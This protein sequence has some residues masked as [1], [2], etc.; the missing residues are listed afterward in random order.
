MAYYREFVDTPAGEVLKAIQLRGKASVKELAADLD[1]SRSAIRQHLLRLQARG[2]VRAKKVREGVG[3]PYHV[4]SVTAEAHNLFGNDYGELTHLLLKEVSLTHGGEALQR[5]LR[6]VSDR[7]AVKYRDQVWGRELIDRLE[8]WAEL[9]DK[10][11]VTVEIEKTE[12]GYVLQEY[13]CPYQNVATENR[14]VC[15]MERQ[16][17]ARLLASGVRL[18]QC[19]L[20]GHHGCQFTISQEGSIDVAA[21]VEPVEAVEP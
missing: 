10:K 8:A 20:D 2:A 7:L 18:T 11:G 5:L 6:R 3:R 14:A 13:G 9:L 19:A 16:V 1:L 12:T 21:S 17:M 4:Y 15:E